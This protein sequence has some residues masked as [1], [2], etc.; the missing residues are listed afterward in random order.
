[1]QR[2]AFCALI[3]IILIGGLVFNISRVDTSYNLRD[4]DEAAWVFNGYFLD[5]YISGDW[6]NPDWNAFDRYA[7][8]PPVGAYVFGLLEHAIGEPMKSMEPRRFWFENDLDAVNFP[9]PFIK[10]LMERLTPKQLIAGRMMAAV[11]G[12]FAAIALMILAWR[13][14]GPIA[15]IASFSLFLVHPAI[16]QVSNLCSIETFIILISIFTVMAAFEMGSAI[17][18]HR[19]KMIRWWVLLAFAFG[20]FLGIKISAFTWVA[21]IAVAAVAGTSNRR[22]AL[23]AILGVALAVVAAFGIAILLDPG[24]HTNPLQVTLER[25]DWRLLRIEIQQMIFIGRKIDSFLH[26]FAFAFGWTFSSSAISYA[27]LVLCSFG[28]LGRKIFVVKGQK[29]K[30]H[31][32]VFGLAVYSFFI[33][34]MTL[35]MAWVRYVSTSVPF[36]ILLAGVGASWFWGMCTNWKSIPIK[37]R[38]VVISCAVIIIAASESLY[39]GFHMH[40]WHRTSLPS[41][42]E[43]LI[44][45][46]IAWSLARPGTDPSV[47]RELMGYF[48]KIGNKKWYEYEKY[49]FEE[50]EKKLSSEDKQ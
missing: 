2:L 6:K 22:T 42:E 25:L 18:V 40:K 14:V 15:G 24:L 44:A 48:E 36:I 33:M 20:L 37:T 43:T 7:N 1:M 31:A 3:G 46:K 21:A 38:W 35:P 45:R 9:E 32:L 29:D 5:L 49:W 11:F 28:I 26:R 16:L 12:W 8:H 41:K 30:K 39:I 23:H 4:I 34:L 27:V 47:H 19:G 17:D 50:T 13:L 10:G